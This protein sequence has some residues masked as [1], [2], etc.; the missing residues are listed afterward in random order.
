MDLCS[1]LRDRKTM[2]VMLRRDSP[3]PEYDK[4]CCVVFGIPITSTFV[5]S[6]FSKITYNQSK[7]RNRLDDRTMDAILHIHDAALP[8]PE[9]CLSSALTLKVLISRV[10]DGG[11]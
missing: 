3:T 11:I 4:L 10:L 1:Y 5:E 7:I 9:C 6:L 8:D 2:F